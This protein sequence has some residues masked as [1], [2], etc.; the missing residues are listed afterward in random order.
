M[1][2]FNDSGFVDASIA[3]LY[4]ACKCTRENKWQSIVDDA[5]FGYLKRA[6]DLR[7]EGV[8]DRKALRKLA[9]KLK[10]ECCVVRQAFEAGLID[11]CLGGVW[12]LVRDMYEEGDS[13]LAVMLACAETEDVLHDFVFQRDPTARER[14]KKLGDSLEN[15]SLATHFSGSTLAIMRS[16]V[17]PF[18]GFNLRNVLFHG[19]V[20]SLD[21]CVAGASIYILSSFYRQLRSLVLQPPLPKVRMEE[22]E[23][24][25]AAQFPRLLSSQDFLQSALQVVDHSLFV[26]PGTHLQWKR[27]LERLASGGTGTLLGLCTLFPLL[28]HAMRRVYVISNGSSRAS[29]FTATSEELY[30]I[31]D[32]ILGHEFREQMPS[33]EDAAS[34]TKPEGTG[35]CPVNA[36][37]SSLSKGQISDPVVN[38]LMEVIIWQPDNRLRDLIAHGRV[39]Y[40]CDLAGQGNFVAAACVALL[41]RFAATPS[42]FSAARVSEDALLH[43]W[44]P[45]WHPLAELQRTLVECALRWNSEMVPQIAGWEANSP[46]AALVNARFVSDVDLPPIAEAAASAVAGSQLHAHLVCNPPRALATLHG[47]LHV[48]ASNL[49]EMMTILGQAES[50]LRQQ[51]SRRRQ[52]RP[53]LEMFLLNMGGFALFLSRM[54]RWIMLVQ[55]LR[56][57]LQPIQSR[58]MFFF[59]V[60]GRTLSLLQQSEFYKMFNLVC[61]VC[62]EPDLI[63][64]SALSPKEVTLFTRGV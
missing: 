28:E 61:A 1:E 26:T 38:A 43:S 13:T 7:D 41:A 51:A 14:P 18:C 30:T 50:R 31:F 45:R 23:M 2:E 47:I 35:S 64:P 33:I 16:L 22:I 44:V 49:R 20:A 46:M 11:N 63:G 59:V 36:I 53:I 3:P 8:E 40:D 32:T 4:E 10:G 34:S 58:A 15:P 6:L 12:T 21:R 62:G 37:F 56:T 25:Y 52:K 60:S 29:L 48:V 57:D 39:A 27:S 5:P 54:L 17:G 42:V 19:F 24:I 9:M 55:A